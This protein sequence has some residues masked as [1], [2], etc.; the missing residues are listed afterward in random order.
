MS[1]SKG[2]SLIKGWVKRFSAK[3]KIKVPHMGWNQIKKTSD[4][5]PLLKDIKDG[6]FVYFCHSYY[7][8]PKNREDAAALCDYGLEFAAVVCRENIYGVQFHPEKSQAMG[9]KMLKNFV[10]LC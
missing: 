3:Y 8:D 10:N 9:L 2:L 6:S 4:K 5:C 7:P 1:S